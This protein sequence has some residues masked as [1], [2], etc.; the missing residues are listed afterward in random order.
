MESKI[1][2]EKNILTAEHLVKSYQVKNG[3]FYAVNNCS[4]SVRRGETL[5]IVGESGS[6][7]STLARLLVRLEDCD[8][9]R[10]LFDGKELTGLKEREMRP[11]RTDI[12]LIFQNPFSCLDPR[13]TISDSLT[14]VLTV[15][16]IARGKSDARMKMENILNECGLTGEIL[17]KKP[18]E[19]SGGQ[20]QRIAIARAVL[21]RPK[22]LIADEITSA[23]DVSIQDQI[24]KLLLKLK[25]EYGMSV[26]FIS[27][28]LSVIRKIS[29]QIC[30]MQKGKIVETGSAKELFMNAQDPYTRQLIQAII[31][32]PG[33]DRLRK[34]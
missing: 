13:K 18:G 28:N 11:L 34:K 25:E 5:G 9:G 32:F 14:E 20:L 26:I 17:G 1:D 12:Q 6:G 33:Q 7:K 4:L 16:K 2:S 24:L 15:H 29:D 10:I 19:F 30:V 27:H 21:M 31:P 3:A 22:L 8:S 23:L